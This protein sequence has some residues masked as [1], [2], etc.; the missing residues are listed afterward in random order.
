MGTA[1]LSVLREQA[2]A[3]VLAEIQEIR[4][5]VAKGSIQLQQFSIA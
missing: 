1:A 5:G 3:N 4:Q 2:I